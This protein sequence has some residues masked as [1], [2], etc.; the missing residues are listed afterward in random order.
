MISTLNCPWCGDEAPSYGSGENACLSCGG[1]YI[2]DARVRE[3]LDP[4]PSAPTRDWST[5]FWRQFDPLSSRLSPLRFYSDW[6]TERYYRRVV[7]DK[8]YAR[9]WYSHY[10]GGLAVA[11]GSR[12]LDHG[13]GRGRHTSILSSLGYSV[14]SQDI[15]VHP[16]W[17]ELANGSFQSVPVSAISL[18]WGD[19]VFAAVVDV[20]VIHYLSDA[21]LGRL[22]SE[23][24]RVLEPGGYWVLLE[25]NSESFGVNLMRNQIGQIRT[26]SASRLF[27]ENAGF[28]ECDLNYEGF[29]SPVLP[30]YVNFIRKFLRSGPIDLSEF[31]SKMASLIPERRRALWRLRLRKPLNG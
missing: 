20:G 8:E 11:K 5:L 3:W 12:I 26:L 21:E 4:C 6:C 30:L 14:S 24:F 13:C 29:Y 25:G 17:N 19:G 10:F 16:W 1:R 18:P 27:F 28:A 9:D 2:D 15:F 23:V 22:A 31:D 7:A